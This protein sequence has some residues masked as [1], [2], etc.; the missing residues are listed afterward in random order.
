MQWFE[1][2]PDPDDV[3]VRLTSTTDE[4]FRQFVS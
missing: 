2:G 4:S 3:N 1:N